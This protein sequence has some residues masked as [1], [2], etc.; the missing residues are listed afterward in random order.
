M[1]EEFGAENIKFLNT[2]INEIKKIIAKYFLIKINQAT[3]IPD[4]KP[5][6]ITVFFSS[7]K[8]RLKSVKHN[9]SAE[10]Q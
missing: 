6:N 9:L 4:I 5:T 1:T 3:L 2:D 8:A 10:H 7:V